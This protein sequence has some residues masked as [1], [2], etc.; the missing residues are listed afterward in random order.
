MESYYHS[1]LL[2]TPTAPRG[3]Q[4]APLRELNPPRR[5]EWYTSVDHR[6]RNLNCLDSEFSFEST[7]VWC[8]SPLILWHWT[9]STEI[10][11]LSIVPLFKDRHTKGCQTH[12]LQLSS[13]LKSNATPSLLGNHLFSALYS[14]YIYIHTYTYIYIYIYIYIIWHYTI[15]QEFSANHARKIPGRGAVQHVQPRSGTK[16]IELVLERDHIRPMGW[17]ICSSGGMGWLGWLA[18]MDDG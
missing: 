2:T 17:Q 16:G 3:F 13:R 5:L 4:R 15:V 11:G 7:V 18:V 1:E 10:T 12:C 14:I 9:R 6:P 8:N